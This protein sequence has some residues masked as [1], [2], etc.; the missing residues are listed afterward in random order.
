LVWQAIQIAWITGAI[1]GALLFL[2]T[3]VVLSSP[4]FYYAVRRHFVGDD[5]TQGRTFQGGGSSVNPVIDSAAVSMDMSMSMD[6]DIDDEH[7]RMLLL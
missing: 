3:V 6:D 7:D 5:A 1:L 4:V 2:G